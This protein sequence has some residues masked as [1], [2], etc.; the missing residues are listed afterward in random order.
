[1]YDSAVPV[2][3]TWAEGAKLNF[4]YREERATAKA[5]KTTECKT[6]GGWAS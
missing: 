4:I 2:F 5:K 6:G 1:M 3:L